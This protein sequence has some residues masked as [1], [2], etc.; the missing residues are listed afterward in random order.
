MKPVPKTPYLPNAGRAY[1]ILALNAFDQ[2][3]NKALF[4]TFV[5]FA[6]R[7]NAVIPLD[8]SE[9]FTGTLTGPTLFLTNTADIS[10]LTSAVHAFQIGPSNG[11]HLA[12][13]TNE[14]QTRNNGAASA[15]GVNAFGGDL[16]FGGAGL[17]QQLVLNAGQIQFPATQNPNAGANVL[18]D[19]EKNTWTPV[20]TFAT[21]GDLSVVY[22][23]QLGSY[24]KIGNWVRAKFHIITTTLTWTTA[25]GEL[26]FTGLPYASANDSMENTGDAEVGSVTTWGVA[27]YTQINAN[28]PANVSYVRL[29]GTQAGAARAAV[30]ANDMTSATNITIIGHIEYEA[31]T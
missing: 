11:T 14:L 20:L 9:P 10:S 21:P 29:V 13:D 4:N 16:N 19:Y 2:D 23:R 25:S 15:F 7:L 30:Q 26:R 22:S 6:T 3:L 5:E 8:G 24:Q 18:D 27:G 28:I 17:D 31:A 1:T 12:I